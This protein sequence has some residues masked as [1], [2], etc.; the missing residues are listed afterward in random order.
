L[1]SASPA[2][3]ESSHEDSTI[4]QRKP[5]LRTE[6]VARQR[7][8][9]SGRRFYAARAGRESSCENGGGEPSA[10]DEAKDRAESEGRERADEIKPRH[11]RFEAQGERRSLLD[12]TDAPSQLSVEIRE[13]IDV[14]DVPRA[15]DDVVH[16][17]RALLSAV[18]PQEQSRAVTI[19]LCID[20]PRA[21]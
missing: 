13:S 15:G 12:F 14:E 18:G 8:R 3:R 2:S 19:H 16:R 21:H 17:E 7:I 4:R 10:R 5:P 9:S 20:H 11:G 1:S 6:D